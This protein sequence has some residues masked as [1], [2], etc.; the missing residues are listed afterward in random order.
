MLLPAWPFRKSK[1]AIPFGKSRN[2]RTVQNH[3]CVSQ[4]LAFVYSLDC[5]KCV[6]R[7]PACS[8]GGWNYLG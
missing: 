2:R 5:D 6:V 8:Q 4:R 1:P 3:L 7:I